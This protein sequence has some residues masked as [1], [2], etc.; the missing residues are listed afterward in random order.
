MSRG[1]PPEKAIRLAL[2]I[3]KARGF[4][5]FC[6][7]ERGS[8]CDFIILCPGLTAVVRLGRTKRLHGSL[9]DMEFQF[10]G[11]A[12]GLRTVP[13]DPARSCEIWAC[14]YYDNIRFFRVER[15]GPHR[16]RYQREASRRC[17]GHGS[18]P[19]ESSRRRCGICLTSP[20]E[21][22]PFLGWS[23]ISPQNAPFPCFIC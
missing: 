4:V 20:S 22:T 15:T 23:E 17:R 3:A 9:A 21:K 14:D 12:A 1:P 19:S 6:R 7:R 18:S 10:A 5:T 16:D 11:A 8:I 13:P 2:P